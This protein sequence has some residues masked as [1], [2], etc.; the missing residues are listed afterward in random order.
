MTPKRVVRRGVTPRMQSRSGMIPRQVAFGA[1]NN[2]AKPF[3]GRN[4]GALAKQRQRFPIRTSRPVQQSTEQ[5][6]DMRPRNGFVAPIEQGVL[7]I[8][9]IGGCEEVG[10]NMTVFEYGEDIFICDMGLPVPEED[11]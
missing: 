7:R 9:P 4:S 1:G 8:I 10:R 6:Q 2:S 11:N 5:S 3:E